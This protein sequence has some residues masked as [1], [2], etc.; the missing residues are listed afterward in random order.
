M[1]KKLEGLINPN[2]LPIPEVQ[3]GTSLPNV[4]SK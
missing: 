2:P 1:I 4:N 3:P